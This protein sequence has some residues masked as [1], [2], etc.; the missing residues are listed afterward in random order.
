MRFRKYPANLISVLR[1]YAW[2]ALAFSILHIPAKAF[3]QTDVLS[4][5][6]TQFKPKLEDA[7]QQRGADPQRQAFHF[8]ILFNSVRT[9]GPANQL[10]RDIY[11]GLLYHYLLHSDGVADE[12]SFVPFQ[13]Q[14]R[15]EAAWNQTYSRE[16]ADQLYNRLPTRPQEPAKWHDIEGALRE[17]LDKADH[18]D[19]CVYI[20]LSDTETSDTPN[21]TVNDPAYKKLMHDRNIMN[22][23]PSQNRITDFYMDPGGQ[24]V[25]GTAFYRIYVPDR[26]KPLGTFPETRNAILSGKPGDRSPPPCTGKPCE[27]CN[28]PGCIQKNR[29]PVWPFIVALVVALGGCGGAYLAWLLKPRS[30]RVVYNGI[31]VNGHVRYGHPGY[32][33][34]EGAAVELAGMNKGTQVASLEVTPVGKVLLRGKG[35]YQ[36]RFPQQSA[37]P[38]TQE[39]T[40]VTLS[41]R[42]EDLKMRIKLV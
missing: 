38:I 28:G 8:V 31:T 39:E 20:V 5:A 41:A 24:T 33:G 12:V 9:Q 25:T 27:S 42:P 2:L 11:H 14:V 35:T 17:A 1:L 34:G 36:I 18:P 4:K 32:I 15:P 13:L 30:V 10:T 40:S 26:L 7:L 3:A 19:S 23:A 6:Y 29:I 21:R 16:V 37:I 22:I